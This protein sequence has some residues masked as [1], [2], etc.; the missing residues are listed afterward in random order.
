M[1]VLAAHIDHQL[2]Y[3]AYGFIADTD[4]SRRDVS[5][6]RGRGRDKTRGR[7]GGSLTSRLRSQSPSVA[8]K[9]RRPAGANAVR[10]SSSRQA[11]GFA[12]LLDV[13]VYSD[14]DACGD[15]LLVDD[16]W[17]VAPV[18]NRRA[19]PISDS[20]PGL[21]RVD[22]IRQSNVGD[23]A[24]WKHGDFKHRTVQNFRR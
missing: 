15:G 2:A 21:R 6:L 24:G 3:F 17:V 16:G 20:R 4:T 12:T 8:G 11:A 23:T 5:D 10:N 19:P 9:N 14:R 13:N 22:F 1:T 7:R 18:S